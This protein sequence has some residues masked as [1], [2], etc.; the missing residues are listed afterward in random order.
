MHAD[1][2]GFRVLVHLIPLFISCHFSC[3]VITHADNTV[4]LINVSKPVDELA[5]ALLSFKRPTRPHEKVPNFGRSAVA[6]NVSSS[7]AVI[8]M[9]SCY[10]ASYSHVTSS[11]TSPIDAS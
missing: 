2:A 1:F 5:R 11:L 8:G 10:N 9:R 6:R 3:R 7:A 4:S